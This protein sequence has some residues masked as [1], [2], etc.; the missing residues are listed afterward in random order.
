MPAAKAPTLPVRYLVL[1][2]LGS[3]VVAAGFFELFVEDSRMFP[4]ALRV[5]GHAAILIGIGL[6][7]MLPATF[8]VLRHFRERHPDR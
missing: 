3:L 2:L 8:G 7:I 6:L 4:A 5:P 1:D